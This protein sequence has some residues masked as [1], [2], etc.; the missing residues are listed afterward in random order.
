MKFEN[1]IA[2]LRQSGYVV[3]PC[4]GKV[5]NQR[6]S[7]MNDFSEFAWNSAD[8]IAV[9]TGLQLDNSYLSC[10]D[11][12]TKDDEVLNLVKNAIR[13]HESVSFYLEE[14]Q[15][16]YH[17]FFKTPE[18]VYSSK[19]MYIRENSPKD[20]I[21]LKA[22]VAY[23]RI[24]PCEGFRVIEGALEGLQVT[25]SA[26]FKAIVDELTNIKPVEARKVAL[27]SKQVSD[28]ED[29]PTDFLN[30][31]TH[32]FAS[33]LQQN[34][35]ELLRETA[36]R[37]YF[38]R[39]GSD[40]TDN[41]AITV[42]IEDGMVH[43]F[44][45]MLN[46]PANSSVSAMNFIANE[47]AYGS[48]KDAC[49]FVRENMM[50]SEPRI[51]CN[52]NYEKIAEN[53]K[54]KES[55]KNMD[56]TDWF[57]SIES[58]IAYG[59]SH[60][61]EL[62]THLPDVIYNSSIRIR[63]MIDYI[64]D[65]NDGCRIG[66]FAAAWTV[67]GMVCGRKV[68]EQHAQDNKVKQCS[69]AQYTFAFA[70]SGCGKSAGEGLIK[71]VCDEY[72]KPLYA[73]EKEREESESEAYEIAKYE[74]EN[75]DKA[76]RGPA[77]EKPKKAR[78]YKRMF[79]Q[80]ASSQALFEDLAKRTDSKILVCVDEARDYLN[81]IANRYAKQYLS[82]I[83][84]TYKKAFTSE[85]SEIV[86]ETSLSQRG[87]GDVSEYRIHHP[88]ISTYYSGVSP[89]SWEEYSECVE[90]GTF[91]RFNFFFFDD[92]SENVIVCSN[93]RNREFNWKEASIKSW[94]RNWAMR[95]DEQL[96]EWTDGAL[97]MLA[98]FLMEVRAEKRKWA[99]KNA[100][101][102][103]CV[104]HSPLR[105]VKA[106]L[107]YSVIDKD[108]DEDLRFARID[109]EACEKAYIFMMYQFAMMM[110]VFNLAEGMQESAIIRTLREY[111]KDICD[112]EGWF[113]VT[114][115]LE[116]GFNWKGWSKNLAAGKLIAMHNNH[117]GIEWNCKKTRG[118]AFRIVDEN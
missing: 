105:F 118:C 111:I 9:R 116:S 97:K 48:F 40:G 87:K 91:G 29:K 60:K 100:L 83:R 30:S 38:K 7:S 37:W 85:L 2:T 114:A 46:T 94:V 95:D 113:T 70:P 43:V 22:R 80:A 19:K 68:I 82:D 21:E 23:V 58:A 74:W 27:T 93:S 36:Y 64:S 59:S 34:G 66:S 52:V 11:L 57:A 53:L 47:F 75:A 4:R 45:S 84:T 98:K 1:T 32:L 61:N 110:N 104:A 44:S 24:F 89:A 79:N 31:N 26:V 18:D 13:K 25:P 106:A 16:G 77:P 102:A 42:S 76:T 33:L 35:W 96:V 72:N 17:V 14:S 6:W 8:N 115:L 15:H 10:I 108:N 55:K 78:W 12:D 81:A 112:E 62:K 73:I 49:K 41:I 92:D 63:E 3:L 39:P 67:S 54:K 20:D 56:N 51:E 107:L 86:N 103:D 90:D 5:C 88:S 101:F 65:K 28:F 71:M 109:E 69:T 117:E 50:P 99:P